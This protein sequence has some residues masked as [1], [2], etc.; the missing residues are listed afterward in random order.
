M[1]K[2]LYVA[3]AQFVAK[4]IHDKLVMRSIV[5]NKNVHKSISDYFKYKKK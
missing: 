4:Q 3:V 1:I 2:L 5:R